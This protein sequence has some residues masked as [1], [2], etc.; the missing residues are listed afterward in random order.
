MERVRRQAIDLT[1]ADDDDTL[2]VD[3]S[4]CALSSDGLARLVASALHFISLNVCSF[5]NAKY[6]LRWKRESESA[7]AGVDAFDA[8]GVA[9]A[10]D[11]LV[12]AS[13]G[14][15]PNVL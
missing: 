15:P 4:D 6:V 14:V 5:M 8:L 2:G 3:A 7:Y 11:L 10:V 13:C 9:V 12:V 1:V